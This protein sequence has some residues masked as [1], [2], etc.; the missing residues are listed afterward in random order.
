MRY[1]ARMATGRLRA[2]IGV[3]VLLL[4]AVTGTARAAEPPA[5]AKARALYNEGNY[6]GAIDAAAVARRQAGWAD[7][8]ALVIGRSYIELYRQR[9]DAKDL[10]AARE[11]FTAIHLAAL[12]PRDRVELFI[13]LGLSL[14]HGEKY[15]A[16]ADLFDTALTQ[17]SLLSAK[18]RL[19]LLDWWATALDREAQTRPADRRRALFDRIAA[20]MS[21]ERRQDPGSS[22]ANYWLAVA[23]RG[24]GDLEAAWDAAVAAW[25]VSTLSPETAESLR[26]DLE[27]LVQQALIPERSRL[28][29]RDPQE[30]VAS[31]RAEWEL[32]KQ[33]WPT[34]PDP[35]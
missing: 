17:A 22:V 6:E 14:Y 31:L 9:A 34:R 5:L 4:C 19:L 13:G 27:R 7:P 16:A 12:M 15:G 10:E 33:Q 1:D 29:A 24:A 11:A 23:A 18:D 28:M 2:G 20:R 21:E 26:A 35:R 25:V 30:A 3:V 8:S 32:V